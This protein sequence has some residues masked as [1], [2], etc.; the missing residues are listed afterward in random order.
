MHLQLNIPGLD[1]SSESRY[2]R[3]CLFAE[4]QMGI[5]CAKRPMS[6]SS[7]P[8]ALLPYIYNVYILSVYTYAYIIQRAVNYI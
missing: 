2:K 7:A 8:P 5:L 4:A 1:T 6:D 3:N